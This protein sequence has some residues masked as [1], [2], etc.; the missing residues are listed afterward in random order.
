MILSPE[1]T[2][3]WSEPVTIGKVSPV[4]LKL[5]LKLAREASPARLRARVE[6]RVESLESRKWLPRELDR[7]PAP[8]VLSIAIALL[9]FFV[10]HMLFAVHL[11]SHIIT[12]LF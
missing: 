11:P 8:A 2:G 12:F 9:V 3:Y 5:A 4:W 1:L 6:A 10:C 7:P